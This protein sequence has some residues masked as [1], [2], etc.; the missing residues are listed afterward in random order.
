L[1]PAK[2]CLGSWQ[3]AQ[4]VPRG[5]ERSLSKKMVLPSATRAAV[6]GVAGLAAG[7]DGT[8]LAI[9][10]DAS[11]R[12]VPVR[13]AVGAGDERTVRTVARAAKAARQAAARMRRQRIVDGESF[14][15]RAVRHTPAFCGGF[16]RCA[17]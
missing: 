12:V 2:P 3:V 11:S 5:S 15:M 14:A 17:N 7:E 10:V 4:L 8:A 16:A 9:E 6:T 1:F 13:V